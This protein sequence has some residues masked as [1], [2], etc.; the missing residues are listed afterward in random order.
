MKIDN[1]T[2]N[3][4]ADKSPLGISDNPKAQDR[5]FSQLRAYLHQRGVTG[6]FSLG[7]IGE[8]GGYSLCCFDGYWVVVQ[9]E[10][11]EHSA[12]AVFVSFLD[13]ADYFI[14]TLVEPA[15]Y[16]DLDLSSVT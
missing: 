16:A 9:N 3:T 14:F 2:L 1:R 13:A 8:R 11:G 10:R 15:R 4:Q 7:E 6:G 12:K 5:F